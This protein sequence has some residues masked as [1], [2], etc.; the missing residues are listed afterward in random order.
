MNRNN[1]FVLHLR[2]SKRT[3]IKQETLGAAG[4]LNLFAGLLP[5]L[6]DVMCHYG[7]CLFAASSSHYYRIFSQPRRDV[8]MKNL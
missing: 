7:L 5:A 8:I 3:T 2:K 1:R 6:Y 4:F